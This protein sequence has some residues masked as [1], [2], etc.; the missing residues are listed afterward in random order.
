M[1][2]R[3]KLQRYEDLAI[4]PLGELSGLYKFTGLSLLES[5]RSWL[6][7]TTQQNRGACE[8]EQATC[9]KD[10]ARVAANRWRWKVHPHEIDVIE[11]YCRGVMRTL[12]HR[13]V[14]GSYDLLADVK[15]PLFI[16]D[17]EAKTWF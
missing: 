12:G 10:D 14:D 9:T 7:E 11:H 8:G 17:Y 16:N 1:R 13:P 3:I 6:N 2:Q 5:V 15:I 4:N